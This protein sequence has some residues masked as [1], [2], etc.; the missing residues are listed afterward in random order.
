MTPAHPGEYGFSV[1][2]K[3]TDKD[4][5]IMNHVNNVVYVKWVQKIAETHWNFVAPEEIKKKF[6]WVVLRH[7]IDYI[8]PALKDE[9]LTA[10]TWV[11][12]A[13]GARSDRYVHITNSKTGKPIAKAKTVWCM[14]DAA[15]LR[16]KRVDEHVIALFKK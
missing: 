3:V 12:E 16:P 11:E 13:T 6:L 2:I 15:T 14:L 9:T 1:E 8:A 4:L 10:T 7:E 5:D